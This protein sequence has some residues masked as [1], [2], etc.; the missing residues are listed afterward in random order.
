MRSYVI[1]TPLLLIC[2][3]NIFSVANSSP[4]VPH[5]HSRAPHS[6]EREDDGAYSPRDKAHQAGGDHHIEFDHE[7]ILGGLTLSTGSGN[8]FFLGRIFSDLCQPFL[9]KE[10]S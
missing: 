5:L 10:A 7:A 3:L 1:A 6:Q 9:R 4:A 2:L 8:L